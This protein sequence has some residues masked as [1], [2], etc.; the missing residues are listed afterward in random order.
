MGPCIFHARPL[1]GGYHL[2]FILLHMPVISVTHLGANWFF[3]CGSFFFFLHS[4][5]RGLIFKLYTL[6]CLKDSNRDAGWRIEMGSGWGCRRQR[7]NES[8]AMAA[9]HNWNLL[10]DSPWNEGCKRILSIDWIKLWVSLPVSLS[11]FFNLLHF[12]YSSQLFSLQC[13]QS[14]SQSPWTPFQP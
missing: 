10:H 3:C 5:L 1:S 7:L 2:S 6:S 13:F 4:L 14:F 11:L 8:S 12:L 9:T